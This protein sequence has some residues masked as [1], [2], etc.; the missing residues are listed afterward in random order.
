MSTLLDLE[1]VLAA[2]CYSLGIDP[3]DLV[4]LLVAIWELG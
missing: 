3:W 4:D 1:R 2:A